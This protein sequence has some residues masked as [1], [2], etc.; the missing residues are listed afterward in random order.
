MPPGSGRKA[1]DDDDEEE[2]AGWRE[3]SSQRQLP[4]QPA[5]QQSSSPARINV[6]SNL[7]R[8]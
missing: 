1:L 5:G 7:G 2:E 4:S 6:N 8:N 3:D